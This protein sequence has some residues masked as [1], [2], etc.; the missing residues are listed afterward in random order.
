MLT[1]DEVTLSCFHH[2]SN[3]L[4]H[5]RECVQNT[6]FTND[7]NSMISSMTSE[8]RLIHLL[9]GKIHYCFHTAWVLKSITHFIII[10]N[11]Y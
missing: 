6:R 5:L 4:Y 2:I 3:F 10:I 1:K 8:D 11:T 9:S 7:T